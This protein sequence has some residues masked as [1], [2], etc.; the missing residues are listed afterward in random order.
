MIQS[1]I[2][3]FIA[4]ILLLTMALQSC[5][6][7][8]DGFF[9]G[10]KKLSTIG[11]NDKCPNG[12][13]GSECKHPRESRKSEITTN[14]TWNNKPWRNYMNPGDWM[15][16][17]DC[18][19]KPIIYTSQTT[20][21]TNNNST[22]ISKAFLASYLRD[23]EGER[24]RQYEELS[25]M[26]DKQ[27]I[28]HINYFDEATRNISKQLNDVSTMLTKRNSRMKLLH[29]KTTNFIVSFNRKLET[30]KSLLIGE[31]R[32]L[33]KAIKERQARQES[34]SSD[35]EKSESESESLSSKESSHT[36]SSSSED[37]RPIKNQE[38]KYYNKGHDRKSTIKQ[39]SNKSGKVE[40][41]LSET[42]SKEKNNKPIPRSKPK[43]ESEEE[44]KDD[45]EDKKPAVNIQEETE[46][47][48]KLCVVE[49]KI[50]KELEELGEKWSDGTGTVVMNSQRSKQTEKLLADLNGIQK[51]KQQVGDRLS[52]IS[53]KGKC[54]ETKEYT[55][56]KTKISEP[57]KQLKPTKLTE[58]LLNHSGKGIRNDSEG[59]G[60][61]GASR[62]H[63]GK[64]DT[65]KGLGLETVVGQYIL[66]PIDGNVSNMYNQDKTIPMLRIYPKQKNDNYD[67][68]EILYLSAPDGVKLGKERKVSIG[69]T[70]GI[71]V[72]LITCGYSK[73]VT[74]H[75]HV[76][77]VKKDKNGKSIKIDP[78]SLFFEK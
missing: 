52:R 7:S 62:I 14:S 33:G 56:G 60:H 30:A 70:I 13:I 16:R 75:I 77:L 6:R 17:W 44:K 36:D 4:V 72:D 26:I 67:F 71:A 34:D 61:F 1:Q 23:R 69:D 50:K 48:D 11:A 63:K 68:I 54:V 57:Q 42:K 43:P 25:N 39:E 40:D 10:D 15:N 19:D 31:L 28:D 22:G 12:K 32:S 38:A 46:Y 49:E 35:E 2:Q 18:Y 73:G 66:S 3:R 78:T 20:Y 5:N 74:P 27:H 65:H 41:N 9:V 64:K 58:I 47:L 21:Y 24:K 59:L 8:V 51:K 55:K 45:I 53:D 76:Q 37:I 29:N